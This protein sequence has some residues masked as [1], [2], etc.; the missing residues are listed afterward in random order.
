MDPIKSQLQSYGELVSRAVTV[1]EDGEHRSLSLASVHEIIK[2]M[3]LLLADSIVQLEQE[4]LSS[5]YVHRS[6]SLE[7][8]AVLDPRTPLRAEPLREEQI[9]REL[10]AMRMR[11]VG[12]LIMGTRQ[13]DFYRSHSSPDITT[14]IVTTECGLTYGLVAGYCVCLLPSFTSPLHESGFGD[15]MLAVYELASKSRG[16]IVDCS[17]VKGL[18]VMIQAVLL[19][20]KHTFL[21]KGKD[22]SLVWLHANAGSTSITSAFNGEQIGEYIFSRRK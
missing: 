15:G 17:A 13:P 22:F 21:Q 5:S 10:D 9:C 19:G 8:P 11:M 2:E 6:L 12:V 14:T 4:Q 16:I 1:C 7:R 18:P 3:E 20:Y